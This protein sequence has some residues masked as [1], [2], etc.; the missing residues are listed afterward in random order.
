MNLS[1]FDSNLTKVGRWINTSEG[2]YSGFSGAQIVFEVEGT[3]SIQLQANVL[4]ATGKVCISACVI[5]NSADNATN[6]YFAD[7][8]NYNGARSVT[9]NLPDTGRHHIIIKTNGYKDDI[10]NRLSQTVLTCMTFD[11]GAIVY[12]QA[13]KPL[14]I[15][16][17]GDSWAAADADWPRLMPND[18]W[19][20][21]QVA[22]GGMQASQMND[23]YNYAASGVNANDPAADYVTVSYG[24]NEYNNAVSVVDFQTSLS[25]LVDKIRAKQTCQILL[26][27]VP[28]NLSA[29]KL[30]DQYG[31]AMSNVAASKSNVFYLSTE[32]IWSLVTW[33]TDNAHLSPAGKLVMA[34]YVH[35]KLY[36]LFNLSYEFLSFSGLKIN[37]ES[38]VTNRHAIR[39]R[40][41]VSFGL[42][43]EPYINSPCKIMA[44]NMQYQIKSI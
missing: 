12:P 11:D 37:G 34:D 36:E 6:A 16:N 4:C 32:A 29:N 40:G 22:T 44:N 38:I 42:E 19:Q 35:R 43:L 33:N 7:N 3:L 8:E 17:V 28:R 27:Q 39:H 26:I 14:L 24:V 18:V 10:F 31:T 5:D 1:I 41:L 20:T 9:F 23:M 30:Y 21:Y 13:S 25:E 15:Q 2:I